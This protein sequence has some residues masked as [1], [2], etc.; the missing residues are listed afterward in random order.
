MN[1][2]FHVLGRSNTCGPLYDDVAQWHSELASISV[3]Y[4]CNFE[5]VSDILV[6]EVRIFWVQQANC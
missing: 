4:F 5:S 2:Y 6:E 1:K 3:W